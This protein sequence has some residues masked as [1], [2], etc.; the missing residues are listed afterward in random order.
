M[1]E[2]LKI[3]NAGEKDVEDI[4]MLL[5][6]YAIERLLLPRSSKDIL[7]NIS[8]FIIA[9]VQGKFAGCVAVRDFNSDL[10]EIRSL[11][12][13]PE[14]TGHGIGLKLV[15]STVESLGLKGKCRVFALTLRPK[16]FLKLGFKLVSKD[17]FPE[18]IWSD[19]A[20]CPKKNHCDEDAVLLEVN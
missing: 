15:R 19:C 8:S 2:L 1:L 4:R 17:L 9:D 16:L 7:E 20:V 11:A 10:Y 5:E 12:V 6:R 18:K 13:P 14:F 3:R